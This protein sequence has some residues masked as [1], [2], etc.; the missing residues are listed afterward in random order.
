MDNVRGI[1]LGMPHGTTPAA[2]TT[3]KNITMSSLKSSEDIQKK[4]SDRE[5]D[6]FTMVCQVEELSTFH[7]MMF[8]A[9]SP[10]VWVCLLQFTFVSHPFS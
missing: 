7:M 4:E 10:N 1:F 3:N 2:V 8:G 6:N 9:A 5:P